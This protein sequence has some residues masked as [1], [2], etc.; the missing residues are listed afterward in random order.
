MSGNLN[1]NTKLSS[2]YTG[3]N[4]ELFSEFSCVVSAK[5]KTAYM[6]AKINDHAR[7]SDSFSYAGCYR[8]EKIVIY[9]GK[10]NTVH[11]R[12]SIIR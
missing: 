7:P 10:A 1:L 12:A 3:L 4:F 2:Q 11:T 8:P 5:E 6:Q 9:L